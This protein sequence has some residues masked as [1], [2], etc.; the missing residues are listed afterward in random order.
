MFE[1]QELTGLQSNGPGLQY[2]VS[3][4]EEKYPVWHS[5]TVAN[6]SEYVV[7]GTDTFVPFEVTVQAINDYGPGPD[8]EIVLG[9]SGEDRESAISLL[10]S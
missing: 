10:S 7:M 9:F 8:P 1:L 6:A 3:W 2:K 5:I 4:R